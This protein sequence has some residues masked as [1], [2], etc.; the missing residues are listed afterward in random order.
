MGLSVALFCV[1]VV[2]TFILISIAEY[3]WS[4]Q[5][6]V[7]AIACLWVAFFFI[8]KTLYTPAERAA[9]EA[10]KAEENRPVTSAVKLVDGCTLYYYYGNGRNNPYT[11]K[12]VRCDKAEVATERKYSCGTG[13]SPKTCT[14]Q[15]VT[16]DVK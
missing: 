6:T 4:W 1:F 13:K 5:G 12:F 2:F 7:L 3:E 9:Y 10:E 14:E 16:G 15:I 8:E 11:T